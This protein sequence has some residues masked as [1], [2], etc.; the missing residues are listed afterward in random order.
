MHAEPKARCVRETFGRAL[1]SGRRENAGSCGAN[2]S[3]GKI[4]LAAPS[5]T[6]PC[7][8]ANCAAERSRDMA[9]C[10]TPPRSPPHPGRLRDRFFPPVEGRAA[11]VVSVMLVVHGV[12]NVA[13]EPWVGG[14]VGGDLA[15]CRYRLV[16][17]RQ[18][19]G[20]EGG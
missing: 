13:T 19:L 1:T 18:A 3:L 15:V 2:A 8:D 7:A 12:L 14:E 9:A 20:C 6:L 17:H 10:G 4:T 5:A 11:A 16:R